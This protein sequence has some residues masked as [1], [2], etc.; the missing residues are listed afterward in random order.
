ML[1]QQQKRAAIL[2]RL[3]ESYLQTAVILSQSLVS[4]A[5]LNAF[6]AEVALIFYLRLGGGPLCV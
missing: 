2:T 6:D 3:R 1:P 4:R 5:R